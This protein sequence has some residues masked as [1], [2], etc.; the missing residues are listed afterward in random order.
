MSADEQQAAKP[1]WT[2]N[3]VREDGT[4]YS[5]RVLEN[6]TV[7][8]EEWRP[9]LDGMIRHEVWKLMGFEYE[10]SAFGRTTR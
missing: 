6:G 1:L 3:G 10:T 9:M 5:E 8:R 7:M 2:S 4:R